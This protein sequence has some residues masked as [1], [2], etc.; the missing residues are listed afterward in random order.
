MCAGAINPDGMPHVLEIAP[1]LVARL[2]WQLP[3]GLQFQKWSKDLFPAIQETLQPNQ[4]NG[5]PCMC[6]MW[7]H[8]EPG[9][10][11]YAHW[12]SKTLLLR[13]FDFSS[14]LLTPLHL[15]P[16]TM[17]TYCICLKTFKGRKKTTCEF[18]RGAFGRKKW[19]TRI[20]TQ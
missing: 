5:Q 10:R 1:A 19:Q 4:M 11:P 16:W 2:D 8:C 6:K 14:C 20:N 9:L 17:H 3:C 13:V 12:A 15:S 7:R 18:R